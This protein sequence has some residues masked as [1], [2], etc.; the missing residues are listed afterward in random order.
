MI[1]TPMLVKFASLAV[2]LAV[3]GLAPAQKEEQA[4]LVGKAA[5]DFK[6]DFALNGKVQN[7]ADLKGK[8]VLL[9]FWA[10]WCG[11]CINTFPHLRDWTSNFKDQGLVIVGVTGY[12]ERFG[13]DKEKGKLTKA[14]EKLT[15]DQEQ[16]MLKDFA[17]HHKLSHLLLALDKEEQ[18][19]LYEAYHVTGIPTAVVIDK[20][21]IVRLVKVGSGEDNAKAIEETIKKLIAE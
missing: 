12:Y 10:V 16:V 5:P 6:A 7:L 18:K 2:L 14:T 4:A 13:F 20:K 17:A 21:G 19:K 8:V 11:P 9:D 1:R 15:K 3:V